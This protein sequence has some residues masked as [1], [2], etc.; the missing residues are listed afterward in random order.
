MDINVFG[1]VIIAIA[2]MVWNVMK[3]S[4][5]NRET[6]RWERHSPDNPYV[7]AG[8][9]IG[10]DLRARKELE[11]LRRRVATLERLAT[12]PTTRLDAEIAKLSDTPERRPGA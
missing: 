6:C 11:D 8:T 7:K 9:A 10:E 4:R 5:W 2:W 1:A 12:D 3:G